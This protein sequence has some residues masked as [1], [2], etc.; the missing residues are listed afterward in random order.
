MFIRDAVFTRPPV[1]TLS[2]GGDTADNKSSYMFFKPRIWIFMQSLL[3]FILLCTVQSYLFHI[4]VQRHLHLDMSRRKTV[5]AWLW[6][7]HLTA[8]IHTIIYSLGLANLIWANG[9]K[10]GTV[11][12]PVVSSSHKWLWGA[13]QMSNHSNPP[14]QLIIQQVHLTRVRSI[15]HIRAGSPA[16]C[17]SCAFYHIH[18]A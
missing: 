17:Y 6:V 12:G 4:F 8:M 14:V 7:L 5:I 10:T 13:T 1:E 3:L 9:K 16:W 11:S 15:Y 18:S 2:G